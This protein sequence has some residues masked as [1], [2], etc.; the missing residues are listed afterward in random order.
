MFRA[1]ILYI[2]II[3]AVPL[4]LFRPFY[5]LL[6]YLW[7]NFGRPADFVWRE[8]TFDYSIW[9]AGATL[10]GYAI[11]EMRR[12]P[13]RTKNMYLLLALW[14]WLAVTSVTAQMPMVAFPK[15][16]EYTRIFIMAFLTASLANSEKRIRD[17][18]TVLAISLG[19]LGLKGAYDAITTGFASSLKGP[20]GMLS[21][22]NEYAL[23]LNMGIPILA[24]LANVNSSRWIRVLFRLMAA[25][26]GIVVIGT[27][28]RS[29][30]LGLVAACVVLAAFSKHKLLLGVGAVAAL[31]LLL[32]FGPKGALDRYKTIPTAA[33]TDGSAIGRLQA[34]KAAIK[35]TKAH[36]ITG[37]GPRNFL[38]IFP[39]FSNDPPRV[40]HN[41][42]FDM[43]S[44]TGIPGCLLFLGMIF[45]A[46]GQ[47]F[48]LR[49]RARARP[50]TQNLA[51]FCQIVMCV[52][53]VYLVPN[54]FIN[55]QDFDLLYQMIAIEAG[56]AV[57]VQRANV[58]FRKETVLTGQVIT[59]LWARVLD[60]GY[61]K[62]PLPG[63]S[64]KDA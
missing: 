44:E 27:R 55:R 31:A 41:V 3:L 42:I 51:I 35:M 48:M 52:L 25:C 18:L 57:L 46:I 62:G 34:W 12:S 4:A 45:A 59:P 54:M 24:W 14:F 13:I 21:E 26:S 28:S 8:Y 10:L 36:P 2:L 58:A 64:E 40:T 50:E 9:L 19:F 15:L 5:G 53:I 17:L 6:I 7:F 49:I 60:S 63:L 37:V 22:Q 1:V 38:Y 16:W 11:F 61:S 56:L 39:Q 33:Q 32:L 20:G 47:M 29:G 43:L 30:L 23:A